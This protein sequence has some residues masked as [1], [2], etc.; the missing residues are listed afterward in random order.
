MTKICYVPKDF[1][2]EHL[3]IIGQA[4]AIID[5][6]GALKMTLRQIY[7]QFVTRNWIA[8]KQSEYKRLGGII[9]EARLAGM[10]SWDAIEDRVRFLQGVPF[11]ESPAD[12]IRKARDEYAL[13]LWWNQPMRPEVRLEK[14]ALSGIVNQICSELRVNFFVS[15]GNNSQSSEWEAGQRMRRYVLKGQT[16][17]VFHVGDHDPSGIDITRD[18]QKRLSLFAG[19]PVQVVRIALNIDQVHRY[20]MPPNPVKFTDSRSPDYVKKF[21]DTSWELDAFPIRPFQQLLEDNILKVRN[22]KLWG[23]ALAEEAHDKL[24]MNAVMEEMK[25][26]E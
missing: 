10:I 5:E 20:S 14:D 2:P 16:P 8:N 4:S 22:K 6:N 13:D 9:S 24:R 17:I 26:E 18:T 1:T 7:Y 25:D 11:V 12:A 15:R 3:K 23:E 21:G 19:V